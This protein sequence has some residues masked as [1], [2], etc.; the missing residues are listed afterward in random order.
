MWKDESPPEEMSTKLELVH[1]LIQKVLDV[2]PMI[3][4]SLRKQIRLEFPFFKQNNVKIVAY[5]SNL[6]KMLDYCP[7]MIHDVLELILENILLID[8][9]VSREQIELSEEDDELREESDDKES[10]QMRLPVAETLDVCMEK[11]LDYF[12]SK[13]SDN[14]TTS[15]NEQKSMV[16]AILHYFDEQI[17]KTYTKHA[18]FIL[19][20][21]ASIRVSTMTGLLSEP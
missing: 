17:L 6:L 15:K 2:I 8:V 16:Q 10:E 13:L 5:I 1:N 14:S 12:H 19:F 9:N 21:I 20:Y 3:P 18:H 4:V 7:S 11:M